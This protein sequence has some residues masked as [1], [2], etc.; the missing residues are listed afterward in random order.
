MNKKIL[1]LIAIIL[2][3]SGIG[4]TSALQSS[5]NISNNKTEDIVQEEPT[6]E[7]EQP[8]EVISSTPIEPVTPTTSTAPEVLPG[9]TQLPL[10]DKPVEP[11]T[12]PVIDVKQYAKDKFDQMAAQ[13][14]PGMQW[15]CFN[16]LIQ[17]QLQ[18]NLSTA[19]VDQSIEKIRGQYSSTCAAYAS[20]KET[21]SY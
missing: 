11:T 15:N 4:V 14:I 5:H 9:Q 18:W 16:N 8:K 20:Y 13:G 1:I 10:N 6:Q 7:P 12:A 19:A 3:T 17:D 2:I 21:G